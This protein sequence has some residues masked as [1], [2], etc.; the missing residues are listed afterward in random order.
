MKTEQEATNCWCPMVRYSPCGAGESYKEYTTRSEGCIGSK[1]MSWRWVMKPRLALTLSLG[2]KDLQEKFNVPF[3]AINGMDESTQER[4][5]AAHCQTLQGLPV[6]FETPKGWEPE[7]P[8]QFDDAE[9]IWFQNFKRKADP[10][11]IGYCGLAG[12]PA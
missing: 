6:T 1:C 8:A 10:Y 3:P 11:A 9:W 7:G 2:Q 5:I 12:V 4:L